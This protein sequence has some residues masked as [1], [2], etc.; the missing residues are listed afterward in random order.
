MDDD[1]YEI[2][3]NSRR[4]EPVTMP[5][6]SSLPEEPEAKPSWAAKYETEKAIAARRLTGTVD[7]W[8]ADAGWGFIKRTDGLDDIFVHQRSTNKVGFRSL[9]VGEA[10]EFEVE[11]GRGTGKLEA[12]RVTGPGGAEVVGQPRTRR[13]GDSGDDSDSGGGGRKKRPKKEPAAEAAAP[14]KPPVTS[15]PSTAFVPRTMKRPGGAAGSGYVAL[16]IGYGWV[17]QKRGMQ[18]MRYELFECP[19]PVGQRV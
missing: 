3:V 7:R 17:L 18:V 19:F 1:A 6:V 5:M 13:D 15:K 4:E 10:V 11:F 16:T 9:M 2:R 14:L 8:I 12:V